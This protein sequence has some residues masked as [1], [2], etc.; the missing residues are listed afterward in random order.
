MGDNVQFQTEAPA[1]PVATTN[2]AADVIDGVAYQRVKIVQGEDGE[3]VGDTA[4]SLPIQTHD[5][6]ALHTMN[7]T[8]EVLQKIEIHLSILSGEDL[9]NHEVER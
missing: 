5:W 4:P 6:L 3:V 8:L 7:R 2:V 9:T 1:T